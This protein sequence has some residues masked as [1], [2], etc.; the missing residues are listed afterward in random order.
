MTAFDNRSSRQPAPQVTPKGPNTDAGLS[1]LDSLLSPATKISTSGAL[2]GLS[3]TLTKPK[4]GAS[5]FS[6]NAP[7]GN[8]EPIPSLSEARKLAQKFLS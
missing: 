3:A 6:P 7:Q 4:E 1:K 5:L 8:P 2:G